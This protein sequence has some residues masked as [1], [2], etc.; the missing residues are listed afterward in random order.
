MS[1]FY[2][3]GVDRF[4]FLFGEFGGHFFLFLSFHNYDVADLAS[5]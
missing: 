5:G 2:L 1:V 4:A 3:S